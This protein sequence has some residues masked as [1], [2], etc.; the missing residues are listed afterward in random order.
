VSED[1]IIKLIQPGNV[2]DQLTEIL[3]TGARALLAHAVEAI[4][5]RICGFFSLS[6]NF[7]ACVRRRLGKAPP[8][9]V[10]KYATINFAEVSKSGNVKMYSPKECASR[11]ILR[12]VNQS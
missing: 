3:R 8:V 2:D 6:D 1:N 5:N 7:R 9:G 12:F 10:A 4:Q 11:L